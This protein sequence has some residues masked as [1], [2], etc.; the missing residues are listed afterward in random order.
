MTSK[1]NKENLSFRIT[2][3]F[4]CMDMIDKKTFHKEFNSDPEAA[5]KFI[6]DNLNDSPLCFST[7]QKITKIEII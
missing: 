5:Y 3:E 6:S 7:C 2:V 4:D 1:K